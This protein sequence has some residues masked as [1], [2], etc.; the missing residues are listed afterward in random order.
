[1]H[2]GYCCFFRSIMSW[3]LIHKMLPRV[4][5]QWDINKISSGSTEHFKKRENFDPIFLP[6]LVPSI[7]T[8][9]GKVNLVLN[10]KTGLLLRTKSH[11]GSHYGSC[12]YTDIVL[13]FFSFSSKGSASARPKQASESERGAR[14]RKIIF[15]SSPTP[16]LLRWRSVNPPRS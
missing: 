6:Y 2:R 10:N 9:Y 14:E 5:L 3:S 16:T 7:T 4:F 1:M 13:F 11:N 8:G 15:S 12:L